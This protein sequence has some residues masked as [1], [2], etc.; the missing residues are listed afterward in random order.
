MSRDPSTQAILRSVSSPLPTDRRSLTRRGFLQATAVATGAAML[1][2]WLADAAGAATPIGPGDGVLVL[3]TMGGGNDGLNMVVPTN[4]GTYR[5]RRGGLA[6]PASSTLALSEG[7][8]LHPNLPAIERLWRTGDVAIIDGVGAPGTDLSHFSSMARWMAGTADNAGLHSGWVGR[9]LDGLPGGDDPFHGVSIGSS[10]PLLMQGNQRQASGIPAGANGIFQVAGADPTYQR[11]YDAIAS[12]G[13]AATGRGEL[14][15]ALADSGRR[16]VDLAATIEPVYGEETSDE[17]LRQQLDLCA[18][19]INANLGIRVFSV[20]YGDFDSHADQ[21]PMHDARMAELNEGIEAFFGRLHPN[22]GARTLVLTASE[23]GRRVKANRSA[24]TDHGAASTLLAIGS[25]VRGGYYGEQPSLTN[26]DNHGNLRPSVDYRSVYTTVL[27]DWLNADANQI[28]GG[29]HENLGFVAPPAPNRTTSGL[30][31]VIVNTTFKYRAQV[32][33]LY[34]AFFGRLPDSK[35]LDHWVGARSGGTPLASI[36]DALAGSEEFRQQYGHLSNQQFVSLLY[37]N[38]LNRAADGS[39]LAHWTSVLNGGTS[40]GEVMLGFS[41]STEFIGAAQADVDR[42]DNVGP[43]ARLYQAYFLRAGERDG[44]RYW[45]GSGLS[46]RA[47]SDAFAASPEFQQRYGSV[48]DAAFVDLVYSNVLG[49]GADAAGRA[50]WLREL[51]RGVT[52]G[53]IMLGFSEST[54]FVGRT[55]TI[56]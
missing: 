5:D 18:R 32:T 29:N 10:I 7:R 16:A 40:R 56:A 55:N 53:Q 37:Q 43:V 36:A 6:I 52:R 48:G 50:Y 51:G 20:I 13:D 23:F 24:G 45:I 26:L 14:A 42:V 46:Y 31:P 27:D 41:E 19:L 44:V 15:D 4:D 12:F 21:A 25:Q 39:G 2:A 3:I 1:P 9:Y 47:I 11:Q 34:L 33:R 35:G 17:G 30:N 54:E 22:Y 38:V 28:L 49:R 8:G